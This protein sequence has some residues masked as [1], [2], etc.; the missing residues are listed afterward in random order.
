MGLL[1]D[2]Y[3]QKLYFLHVFWCKS[4]APNFTIFDGKAGNLHTMTFYSAD[5]RTHKI[6][7]HKTDLSAIKNEIMI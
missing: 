6:E 5:I 7:C 3:E 4:T 2:S 1:L